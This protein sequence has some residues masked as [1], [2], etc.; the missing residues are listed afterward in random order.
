MA[1]RTIE[2]DQTAAVVLHPAA[3]FHFDGTV[4]KR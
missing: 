2:A 4:H 1:G 3:P